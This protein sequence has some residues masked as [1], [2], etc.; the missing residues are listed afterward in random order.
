M[1]EK[2]TVDEKVFQ[3]PIDVTEAGVVTKTL[4]TADTYVDKNIKVTVTTPEAT[5]A[6]KEDGGV[7]ATVGT[8]DTKYT[9]D[10][11]T[12]YAVEITA[13]ATVDDVKVGVDQ[14]GFVDADDTITIKTDPAEQDKKTLYIKDG[15]LAV[16]GTAEATSTNVKLTQVADKPTDKFYIEASAT[17]EVSVNK[18]GWIPSDY[19]LDPAEDTVVYTLP[20]VTFDNK[21]TDADSYAD[22][23]AKAPVLVSGGY[24]FI[25]EGYIGK[26]KISL[27]KLVP[28][29]STLP[30]ESDES[31]LM[32]KT[33][34]AYNNDGKLIAGTMGDAEL[35]EI[36]ADDAEA[37]VSSVTVAADEDEGVF[38]VTGSGDI[39]GTTSV[40]V[41]KRGL[42]ETDLTQSGVIS[43]TATVE[44]TLNPIH[45][46]AEV[47]DGKQDATV[48]P[49]IEKETSTAK[50]GA[51]TKTTPEGRYIA[52]STAAIGDTVKVTPKVNTEGYGTADLHYATDI[53]ITVGAA[54]SGVYYIPVEEG[55]HK[56]EAAEAVVTKASAVVGQSEEATDG[57]DGNLTAGILTVA[58]TSGEYITLNADATPTAGSVVDNITCT[59]TEGY[60][61]AGTETVSVDESVDVEV[62]PSAKYIRVYDGTIL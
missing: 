14:A 17:G 61:E 1:A 21:A 49:E 59:A 35:S 33:V 23:D 15:S 57:F 20:D 41:S 29:E 7:T 40:E 10:T 18:E 4:T 8:T 42:A 30:I 27:K 36:T 48:T 34:S 54:A 31:D 53:D 52:V 5:F 44:A 38:K 47:T 56:A 62:T 60:I 12:P 32:Y 13:D 37:T 3:L 39:S 11:E 22:I 25:D 46:G 58:P 45:I 16:D 2:M 51:I 28:D 26:S 9:S 24:L 19:T 43:G 55:S 50:S 6:I